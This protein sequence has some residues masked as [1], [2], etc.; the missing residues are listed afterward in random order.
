V[1]WN[2]AIVA[3]S[4][5][6]ITHFMDRKCEVWWPLLSRST[7]YKY[8]YYP[9]EVHALRDKLQPDY[10]KVVLQVVYDAVANYLVEA[11]PDC[12]DAHPSEM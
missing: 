4:A 2:V 6:S 9:K 10:S 12:T 3:A 8:H 5:I 7:N 11:E 1:N